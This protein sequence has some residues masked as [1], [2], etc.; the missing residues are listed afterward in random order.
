M[1]DGLGVSGG[2]GG[3]M[4]RVQGSNGAV[5]GCKTPRRGPLL[6]VAGCV[7]ASDYGAHQRVFDW[8]VQGG[9]GVWG[10]WSM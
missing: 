3:E 7:Y 9:G 4:D 10:Q 5:V 2:I 6:L 1:D 8:G